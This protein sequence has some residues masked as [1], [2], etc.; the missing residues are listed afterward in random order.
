MGEAMPETSEIDH[1]G[2]NFTRTTH[3][4]TYVGILP[5]RFPDHRGQAVLI[6][7]ASKG[8]GR[9]IALSYAEGGV[10]YLALGAR[11]N[12]DEVEAAVLEA[13]KNSY[14]TPP[15]VLK[16]LLDVTDVSSVSAA[17]EAVDQAF[18]KLDVLVN[19]AGC[20]EAPTPIA[21][22]DPEKWWHTWEVNMRGTY[23]T[24]RACLPLL[25]K[26]GDKTIVSISSIGAHWQ[27]VGLSSYQTSKFALL[28]FT[29]FID[30]EY[31]DEGILA[32]AV[33][34]GNVPTDIRSSLPESSHARKQ[35][36]CAKGMT[37]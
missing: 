11:T 33:H 18:P 6:T 27:N 9:A 14:K 24:T 36:S 13:A 23:L 10:S 29:E 5:A 26:G 4:D 37:K 31:G 8:I 15:K 34:P 1:T 12:V 30:A 32:Y 25:L 22:S 7:G 28:R 21:D 35:R 20:L 3:T 2:A 16:L 19:N 17:I